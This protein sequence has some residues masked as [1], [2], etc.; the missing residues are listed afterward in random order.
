ML[1]TRSL[2]GHNFT[3]HGDRRRSSCDRK[4]NLFTKVGPLAATQ[5]AGKR[6]LL[7]KFI[8]VRCEQ[9]NNQNN[10]Y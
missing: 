6:V 3:G 2:S 4:I 9:K 5:K 10:A 7:S 1:P 8:Y